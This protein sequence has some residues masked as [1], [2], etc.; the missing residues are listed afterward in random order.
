MRPRIVL[1]LRLLHRTTSL[2]QQALHIYLSNEWMEVI[3]PRLWFLC[4]MMNDVFSQP[5]WMRCTK[6]SLAF[7]PVPA[8]KGLSVAYTV[9]SWGQTQHQ[10]RQCKASL[11]E[12]AFFET[13]S[14]GWVS[15]KH[16]Q[17]QPS[18]PS[19]S[20][21]CASSPSPAFWRVSSVDLS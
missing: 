6:V 8:D 11:S 18:L 16:H 7:T 2:F 12:P 20:G 10:G 17:N 14:L 9:V 13:F 15:L 21:F 5:V 19:L 4:Y 3:C 1:Y